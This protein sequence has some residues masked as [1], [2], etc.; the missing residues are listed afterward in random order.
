MVPVAEHLILAYP[1]FDMVLCLGRYL[2]AHVDRLHQQRVINACALT[3][4][5]QTMEQSS[6]TIDQLAVMHL[7]IA[8]LIWISHIAPD[9]LEA[10]QIQKTSA[11]NPPSM[12]ERKLGKDKAQVIAPQDSSKLHPVHAWGHFYIALFWQTIRCIP[13]SFK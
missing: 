6:S 5:Q 1:G 3:D 2:L 13:L 7:C 4:W 12:I 9:I 11:R 10:V 8:A